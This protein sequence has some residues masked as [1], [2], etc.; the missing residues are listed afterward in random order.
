[1][2]FIGNMLGN[3][4]WISA[5]I[6]NLVA[7]PI[8]STAQATS[9]SRNVLLRWNPIILFFLLCD[10][11]VHGK[12]VPILFDY[13][14]ERCPDDIRWFSMI[15]PPLTFDYHRM[16]FS[17]SSIHG[18]T[19]FGDYNITP[20][21]R[22]FSILSRL[23][24]A[25]ELIRRSI[26]AAFGVLYFFQREAYGFG[27]LVLKGRLNFRSINLHNYIFFSEQYYGGSS[28]VDGFYYW[29]G[30]NRAG[31]F[32][33]TSMGR[34]AMPTLYSLDK[35]N[36]PP[37]WRS[38]ACPRAARRSAYFY[39]SCALTEGGVP[40]QWVRGPKSAARACW[41]AYKAIM[42]NPIR[43][44]ILMVLITNN[45]GLKINLLFL[46]FLKYSSSR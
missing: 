21:K 3:M 18:N 43:P 34:K 23:P 22:I 33:C 36:R 31:F 45:G 16:V 7:A 2:T 5:S 11:P 20:L 24:G 6:D 17:W 39:D 19:H 15:S 30:R 8:P 42:K 44:I 46:S 28:I 41:A 12:A 10:H 13:F 26:R 25:A 9:K 1:M 37:T 29:A 32:Y 40:A 27:E 4:Q 35:L 14:F 38:A